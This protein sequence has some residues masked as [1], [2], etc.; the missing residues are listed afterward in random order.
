MTIIGGKYIIPT[1]TKI[2]R[3]TILLSEKNRHEEKNYNQRQRRTFYKGKK[4]H[5]SGRHNKINI[6]AQNK[7]IPKHMSKK[8]TEI[9]NSTIIVGHFSI[10]LSIPLWKKKTRTT[11][12]KIKK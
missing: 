9:H 11:R 10:S 4:I 2:S 8:R 12:Q 5:Q 6:H 1:I 3:L 7:T